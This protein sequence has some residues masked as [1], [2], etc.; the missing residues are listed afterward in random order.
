MERPEYTNSSGHHVGRVGW[1]S[2]RPSTPPHSTTAANRNPHLPGERRTQARGGKQTERSQCLQ[3]GTKC[4]V[5]VPT[6]SCFSPHSSHRRTVGS[7]RE[8]LE[9]QQMSLLSLGVPT[10]IRFRFRDERRQETAAY[11]RDIPT[12]SPSGT[13]RESVELVESEP[14]RAVPVGGRPQPSPSVLGEAQHGAHRW[15]GR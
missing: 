12:R 15:R 6:H 1:R 13:P 7:I 5:N 3:T 8:I 11:G 14:Q 2:C 4:S 9:S 10:P